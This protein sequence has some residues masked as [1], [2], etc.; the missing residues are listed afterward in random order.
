LANQWRFSNGS[1]IPADLFD[2]RSGR[3]PLLPRQQ[4][5]PS[6]E[7]VAGYLKQLRDLVASFK[8]CK[9]KIA[10]YDGVV[11]APFFNLDDY[12]IV[13]SAYR[14]TFGSTSPIVTN[15][16]HGAAIANLDL[17]NPRFIQQGSDC[18]VVTFTCKSGLCVRHGGSSTGAD[19]QWSTYV[20]S[21]EQADALVGGLRAI[22]PYYPDGSGDIRNVK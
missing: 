6:K 15:T 20:N 17:D 11:D 1:A 4:Y 21:R 5:S 19:S 13:A 18:I 9:A 12:G 10:V 3:P 7:P 16:S 8:A 2:P 22:V 14:I